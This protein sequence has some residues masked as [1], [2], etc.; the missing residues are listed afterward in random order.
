M[1]VE[2]QSIFIEAC[3]PLRKTIV[4]IQHPTTP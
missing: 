2:A 4:A 3:Q 1:L